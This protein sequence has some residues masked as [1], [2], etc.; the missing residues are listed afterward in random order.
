[1]TAWLWIALGGALGA[2]ARYGLTRAAAGVLGA[3]F[4]W[5][6]LMANLLGSFVLG[7]VGARSEVAAVSPELRLAIGT[8]ILA[9]FTTFSSMQWEAL[10]LVRHG[11]WKEA[12][13]YLTGSLLLGFLSIWLGFQAGHTVL[14]RGHVGPDR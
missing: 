11:Q 8:G 7:V 2:L 13:L 6:T 1:M 4:P 14:T 5:G 10:E 3:T 9:A 12:V